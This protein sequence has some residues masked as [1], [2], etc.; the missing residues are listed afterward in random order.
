MPNNVLNSVTISGTR[1]DLLAIKELMNGKDGELFD[2]EKIL[3][4]PKDFEGIITG[5]CTINGKSCSQWREVNGKSVPISSKEMKE[6]KRKHGATNWYDWAYANWGTKWTPYDYGGCTLKRTL[7]YDFY[8][9]WGIPGPVYETLSKM[10]PKVKIKVFASGE[11][12]NPFGV[13]FQN[14]E[15]L[16]L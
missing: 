6:L 13:V 9:A 5:A 12:D 1:K 8:T 16:D 10:F 11:V 3:P 2:F 7:K 15:G 14:G 4:M